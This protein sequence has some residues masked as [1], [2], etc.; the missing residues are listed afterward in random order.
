[1]S[2]G[3]GQLAIY[4]AGKGLFTFNLTEGSGLE[5]EVLGQPLSFH[6]MRAPLPSEY[7]I[8]EMSSVDIARHLAEKLVEEM[9]ERRQDAYERSMHD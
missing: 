8:R 9:D 5:T 2:K 1:M 6:L 4:S 3:I 7:D